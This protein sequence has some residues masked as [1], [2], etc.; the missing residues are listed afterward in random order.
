MN[1]IKMGSLGLVRQIKL[2]K[3]APMDY[4][5]VVIGDIIY[6]ILIYYY[7]GFRFKFYPFCLRRGGE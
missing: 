6:Y 7:N 3:M 1:K 5:G 2:L 4:L